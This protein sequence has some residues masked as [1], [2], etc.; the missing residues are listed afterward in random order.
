LAFATGDESYTPRGSPEQT[1]R[2]TPGEVV[3]LDTG[4]GE[5][6]CRAW[7]WKNGDVSKIEASTRRVAINVD[8]LPPK[9]PEAG[10]AAALEVQELVKRFCGCGA[11]SALYRLD[12]SN[13]EVSL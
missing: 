4:N 8:A 13:R 7:C 9:T 5:V 11:S 10:E 12:A 2:P 3:R 1:E 6:F